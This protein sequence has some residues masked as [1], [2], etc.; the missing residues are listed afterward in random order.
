MRE[1]YKDI[2]IFCKGD[3]NKIVRMIKR[4]VSVAPQK[5][6]SNYVIYGDKDYPSCFYRLQY[7]PL[8]LF[9]YGKLELLNDKCISVVGSRKCD[10]YAIKQTQWLIASLNQDTVVVSGL[11]KGIDTVAHQSSYH[12]VAIL[13]CGIDRVYPACNR[14]LYEHIKKNHLIISEF[15][16]DVKPLKHH[17]PWRNRLIAACSKKLFVMSASLKSGTMHTALEAMKMDSELYCLPYPIDNTNGDGCHLLINEGATVLTK[18]VVMD[19]IKT[20]EGEFK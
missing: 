8:V 13:G 12:T 7:P 10:D 2:A 20:R 17:F 5:C 9:Y 16:N 14:N 11:A 18:D 19:M 4:N 15:P 1:R 6:L 3:Y